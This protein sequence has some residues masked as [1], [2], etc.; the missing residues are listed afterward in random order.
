MRYS[1]LTRRYFETAAAAG[2]LTGPGVARGEAGSRAQGTWVRFDLRV[3][4]TPGRRRI[5][6]ARFQAFACPHTIAVAAWVALQAAGRAPEPALPQDVHALRR[7]FDVPVENLGRLL[8]VEDAW[9]AAVRA[10]DEE[11]EN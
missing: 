4:G 10:L 5:S 2:T 8:V 3:E 1:E 11:T 7:L 6:A 9:R